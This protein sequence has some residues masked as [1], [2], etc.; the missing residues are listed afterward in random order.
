[1]AEN[2]LIEQ[3]LELEWPW[4][5]ESTQLDHE[6]RELLVYLDFERGATLACRS[7]G[8]DGCK[9]YD[10]A[11]RRWRHLDFMGYRTILQ[12]PSPRVRCPTCGVKQAV[13]PWA[14]MRHRLTREFEEHVVKL[15]R[16]MSVRAVARVVGEHDTRMSRVVNRDTM[17][18]R[19]AGGEAADQRQRFEGQDRYPSHDQHQRHA[20]ETAHEQ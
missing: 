8:T 5:V 4:Y 1:M 17:Q 19:G 15:A 20:V 14:W 9:A 16:E 18:R 12:V 13:I 2:E 11:T 10:T 7:C 6:S 3:A